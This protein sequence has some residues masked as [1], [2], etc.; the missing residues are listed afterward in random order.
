MREVRVRFAPSPTGYVH[1][2]SIRT[3]LFNLYFARQNKGKFILRIE[4]T[5]QKRLVKDA[6]VHLLEVLRDLK[7]DYDEGPF[8]SDDG[9]I[10]EKG[11]YGPYIQSERLKS[12]I[13]RKYAEELVER[14]FAYYCFCTEERLEEVRK[15]QR[16]KGEVTRYDRK[17]RGLDIKESRKRIADG[18]KFVVR[19]KAPD[20]EIIQFEDWTYGR[21]STPTNSI[22]DQVL[23][24]SDGFP[25]YHLGVVVDDHL[26]EITHILRGPEWLSST[27]KHILIYKGFGWELPAFCHVP[28]V[29]GK[30][31]RK[32]LSKRDGDVSTRSLLEKGYLPEALCN[33]VSLIGWSPKSG[34]EIL[35]REGFIKEFDIRRIQKSGGVFD[36]E[37]L[38]WMNGVYIREKK[39]DELF[40]ISKKYFVSENLVSGKDLENEEFVCWLKKVISLNQKKIKY[41]SELP[42]LSSYFFSDPEVN[43]GILLREKP[44]EEVLVLIESIEESLGSL[45]DWNHENLEKA[46][47]S[48]VQKFGIKR[49]DV[50]HPLRVVLTGR[51]AAP[52]IFDLLEFLGK[53]KSIRRIKKAKR[54][55][56]L[57]SI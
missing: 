44:K 16:K 45:E 20:N 50:F 8:L 36:F 40:E 25:T 52:G 4:D 41:L 6:L 51:T 55:L 22:D 1:I 30:N 46:L 24:K 10:L 26:M 56:K 11:E 49:G 5:D 35:S 37:K 3:V 28:A 38:N 31:G 14:G 39:L 57:L 2:G 17:C 27:P 15:E 13:Y 7:I 32:K 34:K 29:L 21:I 18:E 19:L 54:A 47:E 33:Y 43:L 53:E 12:G 23:L 9:K 48:V 42:D